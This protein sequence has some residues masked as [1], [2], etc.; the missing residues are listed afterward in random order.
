VSE[1]SLLD[2]ADWRRQVSE[3][4]AEIRELS[5][6]D[7]EGAHQQF[8]A[9]R[10]RLFKSHP[11]SPLI[12]QERAQ[13]KTLSYF[14]YQSRYR[15]LGEVQLSERVELLESE[16]PEGTFRYQRFG[17]V[18]FKLDGKSHQLALHWVMGYGGGLFI[19]FKDR[20]SG[21]ESYGGGRYLVDA[22]KGADLGSRD[23]QLIL[24]FNFAYNPSCAY[25]HRWVCPLAMRENQLDVRIEAGEKLL[26]T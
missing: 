23:G 9:T 13:F 22:I 20:T 17:E 6:A 16:L 1:F 15:V 3:L 11:A 14:P 8:R 10:D 24:D 26:K 12:E 18:R 4:Y 7:P 19:P 21:E 5:Q 2:L 25:N